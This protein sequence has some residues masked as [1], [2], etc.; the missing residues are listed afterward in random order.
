RAYLPERMKLRCA[1][2]ILPMWHPLRLAEDYA[3]AD[4][5]TGGRV[6]FGIGRGYD[7]RD[8]ETFGVPVLDQ[9]ANRELF[10]EQADLLFKALNERSFSH[11]G[12]NYTVPP[13]VPYRGYELSEVTLVPRPLTTP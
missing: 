3:M 5:L 4:V 1:F 8:V 10:E 12:K 7:A 11:H 9:D 6:A 2:T 13:R